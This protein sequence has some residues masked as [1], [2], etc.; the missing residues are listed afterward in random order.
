[1]QTVMVCEFLKTTHLLSPEKGKQL[2]D[3]ILSL[4]EESD[5][6]VLDFDGYEYI[7]SSFFNEALG[8]ILI[9]KKLTAGKLKQIIQWKNI[10]E[11]DEI[12]ILLSLENAEIKLR[13]IQRKIDPEEFYRANLPAF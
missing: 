10:S 9:E 8:K 6:I 1:M 2:R 5:L 4:M 11:D 7:S 3:N 13:L 12:D